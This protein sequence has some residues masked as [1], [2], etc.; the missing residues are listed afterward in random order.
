MIGCRL[1]TLVSVTRKL[2]FRSCHSE[3]YPVDDAR[4]IFYLDHGRAPYVYV[5]RM[6]TDPNVHVSV[7]KETIHF[8][9]FVE[10]WLSST[11][12]RAEL[13]AGLRRT[14]MLPIPDPP[15]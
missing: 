7:S 13:L 10:R 5:Q 11:E 9:D 12:A 1:S 8:A 4:R 2:R 3:R 14:E 6:N 15:V